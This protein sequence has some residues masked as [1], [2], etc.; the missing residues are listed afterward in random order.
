MYNARVMVTAIVHKLNQTNPL[1]LCFFLQHL[2]RHLLAEIYRPVAV[3]ACGHLGVHR[4]PAAVFAR[5]ENG[6]FQVTSSERRMFSFDETLSLLLGRENPPPAA[7]VNWFQEV[8]ARNPSHRC[9]AAPDRT[10]QQIIHPGAEEV[11]CTLM[12]SW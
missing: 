11:Y 1:L 8:D 5:S 2:T 7:R 3:L 6:K 12:L 10:K 9:A 4:S